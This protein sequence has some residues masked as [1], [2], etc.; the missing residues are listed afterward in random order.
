MSTSE[1]H[2]CQ[3]KERF[4]LRAARLSFQLCKWRF[5]EMP[6]G[7]L[8]E[9]PS[10]ISVIVLLMGSY[11]SSIDDYLSGEGRNGNFILNETQKFKE[12]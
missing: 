10:D 7:S 8:H 5:T 11:L 1:Y 9:F 2:S 6:V 4:H 3:S 12:T